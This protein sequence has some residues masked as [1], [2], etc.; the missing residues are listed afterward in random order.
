MSLQNNLLETISELEQVDLNV[1]SKTNLDDL[2]EKMEYTCKKIAEQYFK[3]NNKLSIVNNII[4]LNFNSNYM[5][6]DFN[7]HE[8][9]EEHLDSFIYNYQT[10]KSLLNKGR[11]I[12]Y[13]KEIKEKEK[14]NEIR[15]ARNTLALYGIKS[16]N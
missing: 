16:I 15:C 2:E 5:N 10:V 1:N 4:D 6:T 7:R 8:H 11:E 12:R 9:I 3:L 13:L 14:E